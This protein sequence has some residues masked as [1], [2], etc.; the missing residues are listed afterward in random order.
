[1][2]FSGRFQDALFKLQII[3]SGHWKW[4]LLHTVGY[5]VFK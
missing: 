4:M 1:M 3:D 5:I 2:Q